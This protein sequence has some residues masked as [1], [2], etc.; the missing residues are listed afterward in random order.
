M[1]CMHTPIMSIQLFFGAT[2]ALKQK[3]IDDEVALISSLCSGYGL[4]LTLLIRAD[5]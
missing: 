3:D 2:M 5:H 1:Y 4:D